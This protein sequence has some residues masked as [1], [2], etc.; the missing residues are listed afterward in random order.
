MD[1]LHW[2]FRPGKGRFDFWCEDFIW[3]CD[4][5]NG[6]VIHFRKPDPHGICEKECPDLDDPEKF[7]VVTMAE[8]DAMVREVGMSIPP[9]LAKSTADPPTP[10]K[11]DTD[12][13]I[14]ETLRS[15]GCRLSTTRLI[16]EMAK[17]GS[18]PSEQ[19]IKKRLSAMVKTGQ[20][21]NDSKAKPRGYGLPEWRVGSSGSVGS[22]TGSGN[23]RVDDQLQDY[24]SYGNCPRFF[25]R[26]HDRLID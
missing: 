20:L 16:S 7:R 12:R 18:N 15:V 19:Y 26:P 10:I 25:R 8:A 21:D 6:K 23:R 2:E 9:E 1:P 11:S 17:R 5:G 14:V 13:Q 3:S 22:G 4:V 24:A